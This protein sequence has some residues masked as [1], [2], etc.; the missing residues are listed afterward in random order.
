MA[1]IIAVVDDDEPVRDSLEA[2]LSSVG[3]KV[4]RHASGVAFL[5][6]DPGAPLDAVL[7]DQHMKGVNGVEVAERL[8]QAPKPVPVVL[9]SGDLSNACAERARRA[10]VRAILRKPFADDVLLAAIE[11]ALG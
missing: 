9:M 5:A 8:A 1:K 7:L 11:R 2:L 3:H 10:G 6:R 4:E